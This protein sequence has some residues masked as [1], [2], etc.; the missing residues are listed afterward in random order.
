MS[1]PKKPG[2]DRL[3]SRIS[4]GVA[5]PSTGLGFEG[6]DVRVR[7]SGCVAVVTGASSGIGAAFAKQLAKLGSDVILA[8]RRQPELEKLAKQLGQ[9]YAIDAKWLCVDL[10]VPEGAKTLT[11]FAYADGRDVD[12]LVNKRWVW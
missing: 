2:F 5:C 12:I 11:E 9:D 1:S 6:R 3:V 10:S 7:L 4:F 8:A